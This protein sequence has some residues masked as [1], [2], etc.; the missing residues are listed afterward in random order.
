MQPASSEAQWPT[1][2]RA[3]RTVV[4]VDLVESVRLIEQHEEDAV[5]RWQALVS[6]VVA[7]LLPRHGGRLVK[8][9]GDGLMLEFETVP[10]LIFPTSPPT[11]PNPVTAPLAVEWLTVPVR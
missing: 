6:E 10:V 5:H 4:V 7:T 2:R 9:L 3:S 8:S 11:N 1:Y